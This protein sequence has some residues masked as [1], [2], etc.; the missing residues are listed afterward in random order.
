MVKT[1]V[2]YFIQQDH[3]DLPGIGALKW[4]KQDAFWQN[5]ELIAPVE[6][7][8]LDAIEAKPAKQF[9]NFLADELAISTEQAGLKYDQF[10]Q[11]FINGSSGQL[12][13]GNLGTIH[14]QADSYEWTS[15][16]DASLFYKNITVSRE[17]VHD[18]DPYLET[19][20]TNND[21]WWIWALL[22]LIIAIGL[23][24]NKLF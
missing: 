10:L 24:Y 19:D 15:N 18:N 11:D 1:L 5:N 4:V 14:K 20:N 6:T 7:I 12:V 23:I 3:L 9:Y 16:Y 13:L 21:K 22:F 17:T 2:Q 8:V